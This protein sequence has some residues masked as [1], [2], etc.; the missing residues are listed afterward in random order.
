VKPVYFREV[1]LAI[2][3]L[4]IGPTAILR[5]AYLNLFCL[6]R[7]TAG[8]TGRM[9]DDIEPRPIWMTSR[10]F[11]RAACDDGFTLM[12][13]PLQLWCPFRND[14]LSVDFV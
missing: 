5:P 10:Y 4:G 13:N 14:S 7:Q 9:V 3:R 11:D 1:S 8:C 12:G 6:S 2:W